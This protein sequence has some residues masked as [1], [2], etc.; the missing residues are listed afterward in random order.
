VGRKSAERIVLELRDR[1]APG[2]KTRAPLPAQKLTADALSALLNL[3]YPRA[4][5]EKALDTARSQ[6]AAT[7][8][9]LL[10]QSL[11]VLAK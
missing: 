3:G 11:K 5:A 9:E 2:A 8:E 10:R 1:L 4:T 6:G 7:L